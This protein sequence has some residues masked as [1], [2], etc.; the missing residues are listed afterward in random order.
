MI[1]IV[2]VYLTQDFNTR[3]KHFFAHPLNLGNGLHVFSALSWVSPNET[4]GVFVK[5]DFHDFIC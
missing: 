1:F 5:F 3:T 2:F 4:I